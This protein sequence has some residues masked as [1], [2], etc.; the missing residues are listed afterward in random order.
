M[1]SQ[2]ILKVATVVTTTAPQDCTDFEGSCTQRHVR[3]DTSNIGHA[4]ELDRFV[5]DT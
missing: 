2:D 5:F 3:K 1:E 4:S